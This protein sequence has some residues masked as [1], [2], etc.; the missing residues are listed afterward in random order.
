MN[1]SIKIKRRIIKI[2]Q[3]MFSLNLYLR[4]I[5]I[6]H[7]N[8]ASKSVIV[9]FNSAFWKTIL[10]KNFSL[11]DIMIILIYQLKFIDKYFS[12]DFINYLDIAPYSIWCKESSDGNVEIILNIEKNIS[13][14]VFSLNYMYNGKQVF[15]TCFSVIPGY[16]IGSKVNSVLLI[17]KMQL[18]YNQSE[19]YNACINI[20]DGTTPQRNL[21]YA[22]LGIAEK[23]NIGEIACVSSKSQIWFKEGKK[24][25]YSAYDDFMNTFDNVKKENDFYRLALPYTEKSNTLVKASHRHRSKKRRLFNYN[26]KD[27]VFRSLDNLASINKNQKIDMS[28]VS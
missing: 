25:F 15:S 20:N 12:F 2:I 16:L 1:V 8:N 5:Y 28:F 21:F 7:F 23:F 3:F 6:L 26:I 11:K 13:E 27:S 19:L 4:F 18:Q 24:S 22:L 10:S 14:G 9:R 17:S